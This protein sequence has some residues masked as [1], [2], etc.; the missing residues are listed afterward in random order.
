MKK[1]S[2][3]I[4]GVNFLIR[5]EPKSAASLMGFYINV[6]VEAAAVEQAESQAIELVRDSK[7]RSLVANSKQDPPRMLVDEIVELETWPEDC[8]RPLSGFVFYED[9]DAEWRQA[10]V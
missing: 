8:S 2:V 4:H 10:I 7:I 6:L 1:F 5:E 3:R 9:P